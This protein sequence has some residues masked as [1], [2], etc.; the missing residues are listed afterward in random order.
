M[1][2]CRYV[3][4]PEPSHDLQSQ[5]GA[6]S[7]SLS[8]ML[9]LAR[10]RELPPYLEKKVS[11]MSTKLPEYDANLKGKRQAGVGDGQAREGGHMH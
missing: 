8:H 4:V 10:K 3:A 11:I 5:E 9:E 1:L 6:G 2:L 7:E